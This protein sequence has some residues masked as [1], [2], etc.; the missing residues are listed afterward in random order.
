MVEAR[1]ILI[2]DLANPLGIGEL[3]FRVG[4]SPR[5]LNEAFRKACGMTVFAW[6]AE[7]RL[8]H[9]AELLREG[10]RPIKEIAASFGYR[11]VNNFTNAF[12]R[13]FGISPARYRKQGGK[14]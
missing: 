7:W 3:A 6:L 13:K 1:E 8:S 4:I 11:H 9:A 5:K 14:Q 12:T 2:A 10:R